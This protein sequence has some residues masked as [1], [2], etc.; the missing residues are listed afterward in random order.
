MVSCKNER[1]SKIFECQYITQK[2]FIVDTSVK[3]TFLANS[4][5]QL[6]EVMS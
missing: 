6:V 4:C 2:L 5:K 1:R 3:C